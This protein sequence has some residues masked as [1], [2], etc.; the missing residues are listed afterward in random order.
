MHSLHIG[1]EES[2]FENGVPSFNMAGGVDGATGYVPEKLRHHVCTSKCPSAL[3]Q[4]FS[5]W[6]RVYDNVIEPKHAI[7]QCIK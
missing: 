5:C 6:Y 3:M 2:H 7:F 4:K 1:A